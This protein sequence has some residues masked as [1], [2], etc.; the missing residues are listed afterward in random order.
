MAMRTLLSAVLLAGIFASSTAADAAVV[1]RCRSSITGK[2]ISIAYAKAHP[3][4]T[5]CKF[6]R[7]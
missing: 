3:D 7:R 2:F 4:T 6:V 5:W 1:L